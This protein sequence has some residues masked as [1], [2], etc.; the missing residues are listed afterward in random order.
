MRITA[1]KKE[2]NTRK[3]MFGILAVLVTVMAVSTY[4]M[5]SLAAPV[6][7]QLRTRDQLKTCDP[8]MTQD[9]LQVQGRLQTQDR[10]GTCTQDCTQLQTMEQTQVRDGSCGECSGACLGGGVQ[11]REMTASQVCLGD[12][13]Q[14]RTHNKY[15]VRVCV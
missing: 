15:Q 5:P 4:A 2:M 7:D 6:M 10:L 11:F 3:K 14:L 12:C 9:Q 1:V 13:S 8:L